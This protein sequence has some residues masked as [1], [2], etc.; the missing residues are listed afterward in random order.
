M[1]L[2][3]P[4]MAKHSE[5]STNKYKSEGMD[6]FKIAELLYSL[7]DEREKTNRMLLAM[8]QKI[9]SLEMKI[10]RLEEQLGKK[11]KPL[12][13]EKDEELLKFVKR[14]KKVT[15][16]EVQKHFKYKGKNGASSRLH[17]L[18]SMGLLEKVQAGRRVYYL[19]K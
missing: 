16:A 6:A 10:E 8:M 9:E 15:A 7:K 14:M 3:V 11:E 18:Y 19:P 13:G 17:K 5:L 4:V 1:T 12:L 2:E